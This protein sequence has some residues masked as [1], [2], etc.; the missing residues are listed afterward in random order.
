MGR[1]MQ[2]GTGRRILVLGVALALGTGTLS[3]EPARAAESAKIQ[4]VLNSDGGGRMVANSQTNP[5]DETWFWEACAPDLSTCTPFGSVRIV[6][7]TGAAA[8]TVFRVTSS[9]GATTLSPVWHGNVTSLGPPSVS[10]VVRANELVTPVP[11]Q[12]NGG[13]DGDFDLTQ[14]SACAI[15][16]G[17]ACTTITD[18]RYA[19]GCQSGATVL[20]PAFT[21]EYLRVADERFGVGTAFTLEGAASPYGHE[22]WTAG[23]TTSVAIVGRIGRAAGPRTINCG[24]PPLVQASI[25]KSGVATVKCGLGC[26]VVLLAR[27]GPH[28]V[29]LTRKL[30]P[31]PL[32]PPRKGIP[33][34]RLLPQSLAR[35]GPGSVRM[36]VTVDGKR[37][38]RRTVLLD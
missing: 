11:G 13:W 36:I 14:L 7:T 16:A 32:I 35:L 6:N 19:R 3:A 17:D 24:P 38:A 30:P 9:Y 29:R 10:G 8:E 28:T 34:L 20:D 23:P 22:A 4:A 25:S 18:F 21:G 12:W 27:R 5:S 31:T 1:R 33:K 37:A 15:P 26:R 2:R